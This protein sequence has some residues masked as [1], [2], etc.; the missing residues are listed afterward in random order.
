MR[1]LKLTVFT[2]LIATKCVGQNIDSIQKKFATKVC[3][4]IGEVKTYEDLKPKIDKCYD[5]TMNFIFN[6]ATPDEIKFYTGPG[7]LKVVAKKLEYYLKSSCP[8]VVNVIQS[9]IKPKDSER[10]YPTNFDNI[11]LMNAKKD[12]N[13]WN[14]KT[15]AFDAEVIKVNKL[16]PAKT[17]LKVKLDN[18]DLLWIGDMTISKFNNIGNKIRFVGYFIVTEKDNEEQN[19][20]GYM[21]LSF[22]SL[23]MSSN[24]LT[25]YPGS[26]KQI[27]EWANGTI[28]KSK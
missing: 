26:E 8:T 23:D 17:F 12:L 7:N 16:S 25:M 24:Q 22:A 1:L 18:G 27:H 14:G 15:I 10:S 6:D 19:E 28:P 5:A 4:C 2:S 20:L 13:S 11:Q 3:N 9:Y 21:I